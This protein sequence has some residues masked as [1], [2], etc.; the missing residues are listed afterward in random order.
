M[1]THTQQYAVCRHTHIAVCELRRWEKRHAAGRG[2]IVFVLP[3]GEGE[4]DGRHGAGRTIGSILARSPPDLHLYAHIYYH[5]CVRILLYMCLNIAVHVSAY[6][7]ICV[8][9]L[10][11]MCPHTAIY[12]SA[13]P[14]PT[15]IRTHLLRVY[16]FIDYRYTCNIYRPDPHLQ[17]DIDLIIYVYNI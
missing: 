17:T 15:P 9:I 3:G 6:C 5:I 7:Y 2:P 13:Y 14:W 12:M 10:L 16:L 4:A 8:W 11:Y 1:R